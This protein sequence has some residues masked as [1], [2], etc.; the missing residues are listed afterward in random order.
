MQGPT[1]LLLFGYSM[2]FHTEFMEGLLGGVGG[3]CRLSNLTSCGGSS[4]E[5]NS[6][7]GSSLA[8]DWH[9]GKAER[10]KAR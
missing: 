6:T 9:S 5:M 8:F 2:Q 7:P 4:R 10:G 3:E 1:C